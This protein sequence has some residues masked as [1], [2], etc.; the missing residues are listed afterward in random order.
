MRLSSSTTFIWKFIFTGLWLWFPLSYIVQG[1]WRWLVL[2]Q[3]L[4]FAGNPLAYLLLI[5]SIG[6]ILWRLAPLKRV[7]LNGDSLF[8]SNY[9][10]TIDVPLS[11]IET[12]YAAGFWGWHPQTISLTLKSESAFG[13]EIVYISRGAG[14]YAKPFADKLRQTIAVR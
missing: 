14:L 12:V 10:K 9:L 3:P 7:H 2:S 5:A 6:L 4:S 13:K 1:I 11:E 8:I